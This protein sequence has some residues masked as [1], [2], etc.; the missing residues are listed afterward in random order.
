MRLV[1]GPILG[2]RG[3]E[4]DDWKVC[5]LWVAQGGPGVAPATLSWSKGEGH[6]ESPAPQVLKTLRDRTVYC[7]DWPVAMSGEEQKVTYSLGEKSWT[8][9]VPP[10]A[11]KPRFAY[12]SCNGF[13]HP[14]AMRKV[15]D[16]NE[17]WNDMAGKYAAKPYHLLLMGGDQ[18]YAD[19]IWEAVP[20]I[21]R[22][23]EKK[24]K[25][26][27]AAPFTATMERQVEKFYFDLYC[28][29]WAQSEPARMYAQIP[30]VM[31][32]DDHDIFDGWGSYPKERNECP[33]YQGIFR[34]AREQFRVF[35]LQ[36]AAS[37]PEAH[38]SFG[39]VHDLGHVAVAVLD[40]RSERTEHRVM[41]EQTWARLLEDLK[42][43]AEK[44]DKC[45]HLLVMSSI[46]VVFLNLSAIERFLGLI[47][48]QQ[49]LEDDLLDHWRARTH[50]TER[51]RLIHHLLDFA[52][53][54]GCR[55]TI[56]SG[57]VHI[58]AVGMLESRREAGGPQSHVSVINQLISSGIV[59]PPPPQAL[60]FFYNRIGDEEENVDRGIHARMLEF[61]GTGQR[62]LWARNWLSLATDD[63]DRI[64]AEWYVEG[65]TD[66]Y[67]KVIHPSST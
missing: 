54:S 12:T 45:R 6:T 59:H 31:M 4:G 34:I 61:A 56:L 20:S 30:A 5:A 60:H 48:W 63:K 49:E 46:P 55:V 15:D 25:E 7:A 38:G 47:P 17:L 19:S 39:T 65:E 24:A 23:S 10:K 22:W 42:K 16:K 67:T 9:V 3:R 53:R 44:P 37:S 35:Q 21:H 50:G 27:W 40:L 66:P 11:T 1:M 14:S 13:S 52:R 43:L 62:F 18:V 64:W 29:R 36:Q 32:W 26:R 33:V 2:F 8:F 41:G 28:S 58:G 51:L 57:D